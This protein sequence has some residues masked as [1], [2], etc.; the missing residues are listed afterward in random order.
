[1]V[2]Q[3][4][5]SPALR[6]PRP[7]KPTS[8]AK[9]AKLQIV[10][11]PVESAKAAGLRY[12]SDEKPGI[13]RKRSGKGFR[14]VDASGKPITDTDTL[15]RIRALAIPPAWSAVWICPL[16]NGHIQ[17]TGRDQ[18]GRKQYRY[19]ARW[20]EVRDE[21]KYE[22]MLVFADALPR[23]RA[24]V[25][26]D[27]ALPALPREKVLA[28]VVRLL[29]TT[30]IRV[31]NEEYARTNQS[32]GLTTMLDEHV[33][34]KGATVSFRFRGKSGKEHAIDVR[35]PH[36]ARIVKKCEA[37]PGH[38]LFQYVDEAGEVRSIESSDVNEYLRSIA[39]DDFT[40]KDFRT[41][42]GTVLAAM[43]LRQFES[44]DSQTQA[45]KNV[46]EA[47]KSVSQRLGNTPSVCRKCY[48]HPAVLNGYMDGLLVE[49][50]QQRAEAIL[51][52]S[53]HE[54][55]PEEAAVMAFLQQQLAREK[56]PLDAKLERAVERA[57][58]AAGG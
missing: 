13:T 2:A 53:L 28:T 56:E 3:V 9:R 5:R 11:D 57:K 23:I 38:E 19:H 33:D 24:R 27:L 17:A 22:R 50:L 42:A 52:E 30:L 25:D 6:A 43:A 48:V 49:T 54:L 7:T 40:A 16:A 47:I 55:R 32:F 44:F 26:Q 34:V 37:L 35:D 51:S 29:E 39:G 8:R 21:T 41:W 14:Y 45:K 18:K 46:I 10:T 15:R 36:L 58:E 12:V 1:M 4:S 20:R 31:G